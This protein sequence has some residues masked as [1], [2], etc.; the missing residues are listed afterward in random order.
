LGKTPFGEHALWDGQFD[1]EGSW[2]DLGDVEGS[3]GEAGA[4]AIADGADVVVVV[5]HD[6]GGSGFLGRTECFPGKTNEGVH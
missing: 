1:L 3:S 6:I 5:V 4:L 2:G